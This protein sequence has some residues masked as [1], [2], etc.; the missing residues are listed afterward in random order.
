[1]LYNIYSIF[2]KKA[3]IYSEP[4]LA[5]NEAVALRRFN[6][7]MLNSQMIACDCELYYLGSFDNSTGIVN[8]VE[9]D[10]VCNYEG[11]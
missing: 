3:K 8:S 7:L 10:F 9:P 1:M 2:D 5:Q 6:Y 11:E 4:F